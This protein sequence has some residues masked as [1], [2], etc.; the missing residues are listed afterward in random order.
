MD[1][2]TNLANDKFYLD[3]HLKAVVARHEQQGDVEI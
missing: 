3:N 1:T 2:A